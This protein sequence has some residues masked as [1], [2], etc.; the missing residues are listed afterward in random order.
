M[1]VLHVFRDSEHDA[2]AAGGSKMTISV[3]LLNSN[4]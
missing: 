4:Y 3:L 2:G 1:I